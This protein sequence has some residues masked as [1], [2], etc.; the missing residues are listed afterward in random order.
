VY[1]H[2]ANADAGA[3]AVEAAGGAVRFPPTTMGLGRL[4]VCADP[5]GAAFGVFAGRTDP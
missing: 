5:Q 3:R 2:V 4:A 1:F